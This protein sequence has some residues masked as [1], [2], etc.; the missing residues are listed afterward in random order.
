MAATAFALVSGGL[1]LAALPTARPSTSQTNAGPPPEPVTASAAPQ[2]ATAGSSSEQPDAPVARQPGTRPPAATGRQHNTAVAA[3]STAT[4]NRQPEAA[5]VAQPPTAANATPHSAAVSAPRPAE[6]TG[7]DTT[8]TPPS[9][10]QPSVQTPAPAPE[11]TAPASD[12]RPGLVGTVAGLLPGATA[13][14]PTSPTRVCVIGVC[15]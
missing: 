3:P 1:T 7:A 9:A 12:E 15:I 6:R 14:E 5:A 11:T 8:G 2:G 4:T 10:P 13:A